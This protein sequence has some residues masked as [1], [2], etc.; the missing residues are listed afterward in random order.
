MYLNLGHFVSNTAKGRTSKRV[1]EL[2]K[3]LQIFRKTDISYP[4][5]RTRT[6]AYQGIRNFH[7]SENLECFDFLKHP[8]WDS[9]FCL[10]TKDL[11]LNMLEYE[12]ENLLNNCFRS[13]YEH[14]ISI[15]GEFSKF[16]EK[17]SVFHNASW[18]LII[19]MIL[20]QCYVRG[21]KNKQI[22]AKKQNANYLFIFGPIRWL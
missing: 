16:E 15:G 13:R 14:R 4:L 7:F 5:I 20:W 12:N 17:H 9:L 6:C 18:T 11:L 2:N 1:F 3:A 19:I 10:I 22:L 21:A 8:F